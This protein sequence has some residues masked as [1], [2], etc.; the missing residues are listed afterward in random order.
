MNTSGWCHFRAVPTW[1][2]FLLMFQKDKLSFLLLLKNTVLHLGL[3]SIRFFNLWIA[4][5]LFKACHSE[6][7]WSTS[8][9][10]VWDGQK[11][12]FFGNLY[13]TNLYLAQHSK[14]KAHIK[15]RYTPIQGHFTPS[16]EIYKKL[17]CYGR[18]TIMNS[19]IFPFINHN[20]CNNCNMNVL[21]TQIGCAVLFLGGPINRCFAI[22]NKHFVTLE[23]IS[24]SL[25]MCHKHMSTQGEA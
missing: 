3:V 2:S 8:S 21:C 11:K 14:I 4:R 16:K 5:L 12:R 23:K 20:S 22:E 15:I 7:G 17:W 10:V 9:L 24:D 6:I 19:P 25:K 1:L 18:K 13:Y